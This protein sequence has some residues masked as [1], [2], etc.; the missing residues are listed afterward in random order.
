MAFCLLS[1]RNGHCDATGSLILSYGGSELIDDGLSDADFDNI[2]GGEPLPWQPP[3]IYPA[4]LL[5]QRKKIYS[6]WGEKK[7]F[8]W[9]VYISNNPKEYVELSR[10]YPV[11]RDERGRPIFG[12]H[13]GYR[14]DWIDA[15]Y[16]KLPGDPRRFPPS[17]FKGRLFWVEIETVTKDQNN[18]PLSKSCHWSK[19]KRVVRPVEEGDEFAGLRIQVMGF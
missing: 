6:P 13:S 1:V 19:V 16:G 12:P 7:I 5:R 15:N 18:R 10:F 9:Q 11:I 14:K 2:A 4:R 8:D 17:V 3:G